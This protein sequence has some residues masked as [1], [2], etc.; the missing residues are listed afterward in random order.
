MQEKVLSITPK[1]VVSLGRGTGYLGMG[2]EGK[3]KVAKRDNG[4]EVRMK[5][6]RRWREEKGKGGRDVPVKENEDP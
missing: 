5:L 6:K 1:L 3:E 2:L 4:L